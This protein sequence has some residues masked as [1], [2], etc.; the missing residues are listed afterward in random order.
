MTSRY[1]VDVFRGGGATAGWPFGRMQVSASGIRLY[2]PLMPWVRT[3]DVARADVTRIVLTRSLP[4]VVSMRIE[5]SAGAASRVRVRFQLPVGKIMRELISLGY[6][7][8]A[9]DKWLSF[10]NPWQKKGWS[11]PPG[12]RP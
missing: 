5:D 7:V 9:Y 1:S 10:R 3:C 11:A 6:P 2:A 4:G 12:R 8:V